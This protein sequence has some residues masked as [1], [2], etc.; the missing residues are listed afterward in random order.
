[1][2]LGT[3]ICNCHCAQLLPQSLS[4]SLSVCLSVVRWLTQPGCDDELQLHSLSCL[5]A[6]CSHSHSLHHLPEDQVNPHPPPSLSQA[7]TVTHTHTHT[8]TGDFWEFTHKLTLFLT[9][10]HVSLNS[11]THWASSPLAVGLSPLPPFLPVSLCSDQLKDRS[12]ELALEHTP[13]TMV[14][15]QF[16]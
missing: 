2:F 4:L 13:Y 11:K 9:T 7:H 3:A 5:H 12:V 8:H 15:R 14:Q 10:Q 6:L 16:I 1:M